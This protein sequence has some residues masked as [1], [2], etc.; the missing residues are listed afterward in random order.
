MLL[1][2]EN[3]FCIHTRMYDVDYGDGHGYG[4]SDGNN[5]FSADYGDLKGDGGGFGNYSY[6]FGNGDG[7]GHGYRDTDEGLLG[8]SL[9]NGDGICHV[10]NK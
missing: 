5:Y 6:G 7:M 9:M 3:N 2:S 10:N 8:N 4:N 1:A